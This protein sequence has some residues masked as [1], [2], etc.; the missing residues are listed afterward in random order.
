MAQVEENFRD[1]GEENL[2]EN[3]RGDWEEPEGQQTMGCVLQVWGLSDR[4]TDAMLVGI[5]RIKCFSHIQ[6]VKKNFES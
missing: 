3:L 6:V 5:L 2:H 4:V 1:W